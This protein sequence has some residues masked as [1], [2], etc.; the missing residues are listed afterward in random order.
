[1]LHSGHAHQEDLMRKLLPILASLT[2]ALAA[3]G[4]DAGGGGGGG[5]SGEQ[6]P[7]RV[8]LIVSL[9]GN[10]TP[11]GSE[12]KKAVELAVEQVN[13]DGGLLGRK[14]ELIVRDDK[15]A[16]DQGIVAY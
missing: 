16:P 1:C 11:L 9:T 10:Y 14:V 13:A 4:G 2:V 7:I 5:G 8:G 6:D 15:T 3:C 12:D